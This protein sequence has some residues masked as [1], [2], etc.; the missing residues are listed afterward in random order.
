[1]KPIECSLKFH[2]TFKEHE[3]GNFPSKSAAKKYIKD[4]GWKRPYTI[5]PIKRNKNE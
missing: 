5:T 4:V 1:M 2:G 3:M